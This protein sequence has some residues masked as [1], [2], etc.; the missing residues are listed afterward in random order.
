MAA[1]YRHLS[2]SYL[3]GAVNG[4]DSVFGPELAK[5][6]DTTQ[7][8]DHDGVMIEHENVNKPV[9]MVAS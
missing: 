7:S 2:P 3:Q 9:L 8:A 4:L 1:R 5:L 6:A